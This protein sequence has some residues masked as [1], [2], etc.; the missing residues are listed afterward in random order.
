MNPLQRFSM[1]SPIQVGLGLLMLAL[2]FRLLDIFVFRLDEHLGEI[3]LSKTLGFVMVVMFISAV[4]QRLESIG[5]HSKYLIQGLLIGILITSFALAAGYLAD[6]SFQLCRG[7][8]PKVFIAAMDPKA[9]V[10]GG[11]VFGAWLLMGNIIN[12]FMEEGLFR[13]VM[14]QLSGR[15][16]SLSTA[17]TLQAFL[18]GT[19]HL[20]WVFKSYR[21]GYIKSISE[22]SFSAASNFLPQF[23]LGLVWGYMY[24]KT[25][26]LWTS[27][28]SHT[29]TNT[30]INFIHIRTDE[31]LDTGI[32]IRM[33]VY[34][35]IM[36]LGIWLIKYLA[37]RFGMPSI[38][39]FN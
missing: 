27:W 21:L 22:I 5:L 15:K 2:S 25:N 13:G 7:L 10:S 12:S 8:H 33:S 9:G 18:F 38:K 14:L 31:G 24:L 4:G 39:L 35:I 34:T 37:N 3:I 1:E 20:P 19:W 30:C 17:N 28:I 32:A 16:L 29:F 11:L 36:L 23:S 26:N 6:Y